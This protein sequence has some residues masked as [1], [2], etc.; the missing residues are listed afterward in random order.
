M[1]K[2]AYL[3]RFIRFIWTKFVGNGSVNADGSLW[4]AVLEADFYGLPFF[5]YEKK[6]VLYI[7]YGKKFI[8]WEIQSIVF[9]LL[10]DY[11]FY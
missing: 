5:M 11:S 8:I 1:N 2:Q 9:M 4:T 10:V 6:M 7:N 3:N